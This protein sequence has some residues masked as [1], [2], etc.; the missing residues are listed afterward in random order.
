MAPHR[1]AQVVLPSRAG[2]CLTSHHNHTWPVRGQ[3]LYNTVNQGFELL[4]VYNIWW[5]SGWFS[6]VMNSFCLVLIL[7]LL[8]FILVLVLSL[9][10]S[11]HC[12]VIL[13]CSPVLLKPLIC[14]SAYTLLCLFSI[15]VQLNSNLSFP[16]S[17][18]VSIVSYFPDFHSRLFASFMLM[19]Y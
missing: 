16:P 13:L 9:N 18:W 15:H 6:S 4:C 10:L 7:A 11:C 3:Q 14:L 5:E 2:L 17:A 19:E 12:F 1:S 8:C